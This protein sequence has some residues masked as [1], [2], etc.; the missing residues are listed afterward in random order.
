MNDCAHSFG[1]RV[2]FCPLEQAVHKTGGFVFVDVH[3][4]EA[5]AL[6]AE[7]V[8]VKAKIKRKKGRLRMLSSKVMISSSCM[9]LRAI[10]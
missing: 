9:S 7:L 8:F 10:S 6:M 1:L 5:V 2:K 4:D 3:P